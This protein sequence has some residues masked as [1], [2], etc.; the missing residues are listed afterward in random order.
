LTEHQEAP[1]ACKKLSDEV[2]VWLSVW[3]KVQIVCLL[4]VQLMPLH[5]KTPSPLVS[6]KSRLVNLFW[7][8]LTQFVLAKRPLNGFSSS[9]SSSGGG[10]GS[11]SSSSRHN[12]WHNISLSINYW[13]VSMMAT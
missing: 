1:L 9:S 10:V 6:T 13:N 8:R 12:N 11:S 4:I 7:Y 5:P 3:D 2:L